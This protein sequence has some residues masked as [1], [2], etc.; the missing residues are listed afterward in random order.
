MAATLNT[1]HL[2][3]SPLPRSAYTVCSHCSPRGG[4][5]VS[6]HIDR[7]STLSLI[8]SRMPDM[9]SDVGGIVQGCTPT[10]GAVFPPLHPLPTPNI[11]HERSSP[12][13]LLQGPHA[14]ALACSHA[15]AALC[16]ATGDSLAS[17]YSKRRRCWGL[18]LATGLPFLTSDRMT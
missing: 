13:C 9:I 5:T 1:W 7:K 4:F 17:I 11:A 8:N 2:P 15:I 18:L 10:S 14:E 6:C 16:P 3:A 12:C